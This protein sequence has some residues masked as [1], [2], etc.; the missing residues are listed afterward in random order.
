MTIV[1]V[2]LLSYFFLFHFAFNEKRRHR[3]DQ[4]CRFVPALHHHQAHFI[5]NV[6]CFIA[7]AETNA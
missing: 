7:A 3:C 4:V 5:M 2:K 1:V 6:R